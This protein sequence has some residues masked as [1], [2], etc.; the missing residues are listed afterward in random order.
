[1]LAMRCGPVCRQNGCGLESGADDRDDPGV[2]ARPA[3]GEKGT[4]EDLEEG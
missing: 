2:E 3:D 4:T 1:M